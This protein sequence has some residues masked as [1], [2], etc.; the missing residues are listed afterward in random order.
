MS[1]CTPEGGLVFDFTRRK[2]FAFIDAVSAM[3]A[4]NNQTDQLVAVLVQNRGSASAFCKG[5][6]VVGQHLSADPRVAQDID[7]GQ[8]CTRRGV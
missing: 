8:L 5:C 6:A 2:R 1:I 4:C 3:G 7:T